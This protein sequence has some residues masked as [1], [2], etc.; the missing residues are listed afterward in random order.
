MGKIL[1]ISG[2]EVDPL[3]MNLSDFDIMDIAHSLS[4]QCRFAGHVPFFYSVAEH[5]CIAAS[6]ASWSDGGTASP[7]RGHKLYRSILLHDADEAYLQDLV[8]PV[9]DEPAFDFYRDAGDRI[10]EQIGDVFDVF[11][12]SDPEYADVHRADMAAYQWE[13]GNIRTGKVKGHSPDEARN[14]FMGMWYLL[15]PSTFG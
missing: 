14:L 6:L 4:M 5:C 3:S 15:R 9:K 2:R 12:P 13:R 10:H 7:P 8:K 1:T 11:T